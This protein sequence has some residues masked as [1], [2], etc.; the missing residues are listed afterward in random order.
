M[1]PSRL[2]GAG[3][4]QHEGSELVVLTEARLQRFQHCWHCFR[5]VLVVGCRLGGAG[6]RI[7][8]RGTVSAQMQ[9]PRGQTR[10]GS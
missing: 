1:A 9:Y 3:L 2:K 5:E 10:S 7:F 6:P 4:L 8:D